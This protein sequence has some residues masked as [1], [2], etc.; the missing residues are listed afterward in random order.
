MFPFVAE[1]VEEFLDDS[2]YHKGVKRVMR[3]LVNVENELYNAPMFMND[4]A[5]AKVKQNL[6]SFGKYFQLCQNQATA[7]GELC[8]HLSPKVHQSLH[9][10]KQCLLINPRFVQNYKEES[11]VGKIT[12]IWAGCANGCYIGTV[13]RSVLIKYLVGIFLLMNIVIYQ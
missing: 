8:F 3:A 5:K 11:F 4:V 12:K 10:Y 13:Q 7:K 2:A 1:M 6:E 9:I